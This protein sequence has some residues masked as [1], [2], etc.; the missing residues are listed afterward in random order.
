MRLWRF[1]GV[2]DNRH[3]LR[4]LRAGCGKNSRLFARG[5]MMHSWYFF[6]DVDIVRAQFSF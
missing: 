1:S 3:S 5:K 2:P 4:R 6:I